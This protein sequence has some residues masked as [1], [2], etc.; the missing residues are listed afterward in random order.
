[1]DLV[2]IGT[3]LKKRIKECGYLQTKFAEEAGISMSTLRKQING[4]MPYRC[5]DLIKYAELLNC[6]Y[7]YLLGYSKSTERVNADIVDKTGLSIEAVKNLVETEKMKS[8]K[9][10]S[11]EENDKAIEII[12]NIQE[13]I[14][15]IICD[16]NFVYDLLL[17]VGNCVPLQKGVNESIDFMLRGNKKIAN[18]MIKPNMDKITLASLMADIE[19]IRLILRPELIEEMKEDI[20]KVRR[21][22]KAI[23]TQAAVKANE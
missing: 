2:T 10:N 7:D 4:T 15:L 14:S 22:L 1:M 23:P 12:K 3:I 9:Y 17:Y 21:K 20:K 16:E 5:D 8:A 19:R 13:L 18:E 11:K 6:S